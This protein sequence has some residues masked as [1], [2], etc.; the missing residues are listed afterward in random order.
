MTRA[1]GACLSLTAIALA[2]APATATSTASNAQD[3]AFVTTAAQGG[4]AEVQDANV[5]LQN[6]GS[7]KVKAFAERMIAD[8]TKANMQLTEIAKSDGFTLPSGLSATDATMKSELSMEKGSSFDDA[9]L[10]GQVA[11]HE[12]MAAALEKEVAAGKNPDLIGFAKA[13]LPTIESHLS[14]AKADVSSMSM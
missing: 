6:G 3:A 1:L 8:H 11:G 12:K 9:Y 14:M 13:T 5:A 7:A 4:M 10:K 2:G